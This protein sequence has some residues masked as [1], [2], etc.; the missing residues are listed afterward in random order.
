MAKWYARDFRL[1]SWQ[2]V[3]FMNPETTLSIVMDV[4][5][6]STLITRF[7]EFLPTYFVNLGWDDVDDVLG[8][9]LS[10]GTEYRKGADRSIKGMMNQII[11]DLSCYQ[12]TE[13]DVGPINLRLLKHLVGGKRPGGYAYPVERFHKWLETQPET[14]QK[15]TKKLSLVWSRGK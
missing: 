6:S 3:L 15:P 1:G 11:M 8:P 2:L 9:I 12:F 14:S 5:P 10:K 13:R 4:A 7:S